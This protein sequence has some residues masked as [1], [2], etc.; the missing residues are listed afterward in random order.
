METILS[1]IEE[2]NKSQTVG[3]NLVV[4][5]LIVNKD[6][7]NKKELPFIATEKWIDQLGNRLQIHS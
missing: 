4:N 3:D 2:L 6:K 1:Q 7:G 5:K